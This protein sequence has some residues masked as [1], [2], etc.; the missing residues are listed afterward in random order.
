MSPTPIREYCVD[1]LGLCLCVQV[2]AL[3]GHTNTVASVITQP[4]DPQVGWKE[5]VV[6]VGLVRIRVAPPPPPLP[7]GHA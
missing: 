5:G 6:I 1:I 2:F 3:G 4:T 7:A